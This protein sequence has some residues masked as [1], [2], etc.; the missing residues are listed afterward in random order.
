VAAVLNRRIP[1][2]DLLVADRTVVITDDRPFN[3]YYLLR[4]ARGARA[5]D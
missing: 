5:L 1:V 4:R 3:E 2:E